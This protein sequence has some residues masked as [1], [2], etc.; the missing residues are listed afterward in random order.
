MLED[1]ICDASVDFLGKSVPQD[2]SGA[3]RAPSSRSRPPVASDL[4]PRS[5]TAKVD[6]AE[7]TGDVFSDSDMAVAFGI[8]L[9]ESGS[10]QPPSLAQEPEMKKKKKSKRDDADCAKSS[11]ASKRSK[12]T[13]TAALSKPAS[14]ESPPCD[15]DRE[16]S[17]MALVLALDEA[18]A[19]AVAEAPQ[20]TQ[21]PAVS[22][23]PESGDAQDVDMQ[24]TAPVDASALAAAIESEVFDRHRGW[25]EYARATNGIVQALRAPDAAALRAS[26]LSGA[27]SPASL[28]DMTPWDAASKATKDKFAK[29][30]KQ[31]RR[32]KRAEA[33]KFASA[34]AGVVCKICLNCKVTVEARQ[35]RSGDEA[36]SDVYICGVCNYSWIKNG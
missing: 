8:L 23:P 18:R 32:R 7:L 26:L 31:E 19:G 29:K 2:E 30:R 16:A 11:E 33:K 13:A 27:V 22:H 14:S 6:A 10:A 1:A 12:A 28:A 4:S 3:T 34:R 15:A 17:R 21:Q 36:T 5:K 9:S 35:L 20:Q 25:R 24:G